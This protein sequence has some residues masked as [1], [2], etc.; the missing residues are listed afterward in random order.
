LAAPELAHPTLGRFVNHRD[1][2][3]GLTVL[4]C[5][6]GREP[7]TEP[8]AG[9]LDRVLVDDAHHA[10]RIARAASACSEL[11]DGSV[12]HRALED[13]LELV[14]SRVAAGRLARHGSDRLGAALMALA[15]ER[16]R[17]L[18]IETFEVTLQRD[19]AALAL[20]VLRPDLTLRER[21][22]LLPTPSEAT[23]LDL[24]GWL[25]DMIVDDHAT[26]RSSWLRACALYTAI[27]AGR[28][29]TLD[30]DALRVL[31]EPLVLE[32]LER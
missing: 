4:E 16:R 17:S 12:I 24:S 25:A 30:L 9:E 20:P 7:A 22:T 1:R 5:V 19:E 28:A 32:L 21:I 3:L 26:W 18:A 2:E 14:R 23:P 29:V 15:D 10:A 6:V 27:E 11:A 31:D 8:L 13:E